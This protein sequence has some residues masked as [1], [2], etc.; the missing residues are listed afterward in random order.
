M[1]ALSRTGPHAEAKWMKINHPRANQRYHYEYDMYTIVTMTIIGLIITWSLY[2]HII[3]GR[4]HI[5]TCLP[6]HIQGT[7]H[8]IHHK[9]N[10]KTLLVR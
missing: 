2:S 4:T 5:I 1:K 9:Y 7:P 8:P 10:A 3:T 6:Y